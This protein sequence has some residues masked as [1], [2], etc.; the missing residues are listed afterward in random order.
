MEKLN[1]RT[2]A[3]HDGIEAKAQTICFIEA[4]FELP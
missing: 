2:A 4:E 1:A 3:A